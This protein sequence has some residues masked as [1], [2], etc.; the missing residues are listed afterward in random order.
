VFVWRCSCIAR[1]WILHS[2]SLTRLVAFLIIFLVAFPHYGSPSRHLASG[3]D[4]FFSDYAPTADLLAYSRNITDI[5][6]GKRHVQVLFC[7]RPIA[8]CFSN[9][10]RASARTARCLASG[11]GAETACKHSVSGAGDHQRP[12]SP[13]IAMSQATPRQDS[14]CSSGTRPGLL[15]GALPA[16]AEAQV[17]ERKRPPKATQPGPRD[18]TSKPGC[19]KTQAGKGNIRR[20]IDG[21]RH[22]WVLR[23]SVP[24]NHRGHQRRQY[25]H[26]AAEGSSSTAAVR[27]AASGRAT[28]T[29]NARPR[30]P[31]GRGRYKARTRSSRCVANV[32]CDL[33]SPS[34]AVASWCRTYEKDTEL[35]TPSGY[36]TPGLVL[37]VA[38]QL[39]VAISPGFFIGYP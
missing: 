18:H 2:H 8:T 21:P 33:R 9:I 24:A 19:S 4:L 29:G 38:P 25:T 30:Q 27:H 5:H 32:A 20:R 15:P 28:E 13:P 6:A 17:T 1:R 22:G 11:A 31:P 16:L 35:D 36:C 37:P 7:P 14:R 34:R 26:R 12:A 10:A 3:L 39:P 23:P